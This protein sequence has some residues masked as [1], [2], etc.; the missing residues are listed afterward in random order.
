MRAARSPSR[1]FPRTRAPCSWLRHRCLFLSLWGPAPNTLSVNQKKDRILDHWH[2]LLS[3]QLRQPGDGRD[4]EDHK[5]CKGSARIHFRRDHRR[6]EPSYIPP[7]FSLRL[8]HPCSFSQNKRAARPAK[9][10]PRSHASSLK[11]RRPRGLRGGWPRVQGPPDM[12]RHA[13]SSAPPNTATIRGG[14][15]GRSPSAH[16][17]P[18]RCRRI[19][20]RLSAL[21]GRS[22]AAVASFGLHLSAARA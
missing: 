11:T 17:G 19:D 1:S 5:A 8:V 7:R 6:L 2:V 13:R 9:G 10:S 4:N 15:P 22:L 18:H 21:N 20:S 12:L 16:G 3:N 14:P